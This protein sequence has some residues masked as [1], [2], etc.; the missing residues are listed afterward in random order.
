M[1]HLVIPVE[2][3]RKEKKVNKMRKSIISL[4][5]QNI[6][7]FLILIVASCSLAN[8]IPPSDSELIDIFNKNKVRLSSMVEKIIKYKI[9]EIRLDTNN[10]SSEH[11]SFFEENMKSTSVKQINVIQNRKKEVEFVVYSSGW[12]TGGT[13]KGFVYTQNRVFNI[14]KD[15]DL[16]ARENKRKDVFAYRKLSTNWYL[17]Y[18][19]NR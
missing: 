4:L 14:V 3:F 2:V 16:Y 9:D 12:V 8:E 15:L 10:I 18:E 1:P 13:G 6:I 7:Y 11:H 5:Q 17:F 19:H